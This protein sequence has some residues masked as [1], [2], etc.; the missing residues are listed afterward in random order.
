MGWLG[1]WTY[2]KS[3][4]LSRA[5]GAVTAYQMRLLVGQS[6]GASGEDV[7]CGNLCRS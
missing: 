4:T 6:S 3:I 5:S 2:R 1:G 7:D